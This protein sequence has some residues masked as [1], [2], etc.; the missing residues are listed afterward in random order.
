MLKNSFDIR[1]R[2]LGIFTLG[3]RDAQ[4]AQRIMLNDRANL[5]L[6]HDV[7]RNASY[8]FGLICDGP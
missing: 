7:V 5:R 8:S 2:A 6:V 1:S 4:K 3:T